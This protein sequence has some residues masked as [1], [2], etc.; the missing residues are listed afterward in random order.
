M[1]SISTGTNPCKLT[2]ISKET[3][4][5]L[6]TEADVKDGT[7]CTY[8]NRINICVRG[9]CQVSKAICLKVRK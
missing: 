6:K 5:I 4:D 7:L 3:S 2:C 9:I 8:E 1:N